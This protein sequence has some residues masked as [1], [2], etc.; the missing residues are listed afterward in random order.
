MG[1]LHSLL[2]MHWDHE[3]D[4]RPSPCPLPARRGEGGRRP[5]DGR[6]MES[7]H[8]FFVA[9]WVH[10]R[11]G[12]TPSSPD[13][14]WM[15]IGARRSLAPPGSWKELPS[16]KLCHHQTRSNFGTPSLFLLLFKLLDLFL[17]QRVI[18]FGRLFQQ[19]HAGGFVLVHAIA[20]QVT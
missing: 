13:L 2:R 4:W 19:L 16:T 7:S 12:E 14:E 9:H 10:E 15:E 1:S 18:L 6:F 3:P 17:R 11:W 20:L 5:G 8:D